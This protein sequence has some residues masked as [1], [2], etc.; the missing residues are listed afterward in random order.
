MA[1]VYAVF[2]HD[3]HNSDNLIG[4]AKKLTDIH[5]FIASAIYNGIQTYG[6]ELT[7]DKQ[8]K[9]FLKDYENN[10]NL[11]NNLDFV[12]FKETT[13]L[14]DTYY[15]DI[16][17]STNLHNKKITVT[18]GMQEKFC[19]KRGDQFEIHVDDT[20]LYLQKLPVCTFC[21]IRDP[22]RLSRFNNSYI[23]SDCMAKIKELKG[24]TI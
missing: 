23:C 19:I 21:R 14:P 15:K 1:K 5:K 18:F 2:L 6:T 3:E 10:P 13:D 8:A 9:Q 7:A 17:Y 22:E 11:I 4:V 16:N 20:S 24:D 12:V